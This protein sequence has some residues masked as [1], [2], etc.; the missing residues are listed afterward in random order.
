[1]SSLIACPNCRHEIAVNDALEAKLSDQ[2]RRDLESE[3]RTQQSEVLS[4]KKQLAARE[5]ALKQ[6]TE[7][8]SAKIAAGIE[9]ERAKVLAEAQ[10]KAK[11]ALD[12]ELTDRASQIKE[13]QGK[14]TAAQQNELELRKKERELEAKADELKLTVARELDTERGKIRETAMKQFHEE[15][16]LKD[17]EKQKMI[18]DMRRQIDEL[19]RKAEQG[20][21]Q[22]QG[23]V[24]EL[25]LESMLEASFPV[26]SIEPVGKGVNGAD[27]KQVVYCPSGTTCGSILWE[28]KRTKSFSKSWLPK[29]RDDQRTARASV[30]VLVTQSLPEG[31]ETFTLTDGV[32]VCSWKCAKG[33]AM[34]LR[35]GLIEVG[36]S[37]LASQGRAEKMELVYNYLSSAEFQRSVEGIVE[38][39]VS[40]QSDL[41]SEKRSMKRLWN[42]REK[43]IDRAIHNTAGLYGDLQGIIGASMPAVEGLSMPRIEASEDSSRNSAA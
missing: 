3:L 42:K 9:A 19:K 12:V 18:S 13:L 33:L 37:Q 15:H 39:F 6:E 16:H 21:V 43:Q 10:L 35:T 7:S 29:L 34:A 23:E 30:A 41:E 17:A 32:W 2:I 11:A 1:M 5:A 28:S 8:L 40:M 26:D 38:A 27:C 36:K 14:L 31:V 20:S 24:Q 25:A 22:T 4:A